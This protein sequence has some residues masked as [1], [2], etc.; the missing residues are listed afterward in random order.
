VI[1]VTGGAGFIGSHLCDALVA[2]GE[3]VRVLDDLSTGSEANLA[4]SRGS[5]E[6][7]R[8]SIVDPAAVARAVARAEVVFHLAAIPSV[9]RSFEEPELCHAVNATGTLNV[10]LAAARAKVRRLVFASSCAIYGDAGRQAIAEKR[11]PSPKSP[12]AAQKLLGEHYLTLYGEAFGLA[13]VALR[14]FNVYGPRQDPRSPYSGVISIFCERALRG[15]QVTIHGDGR[16]TRDFVEVGDVVQ[17]LLLAADAQGACGIFN[18]GSGSSHTLL[19]LHREIAR[20]TGSTAA[21]RHGPARPGDVRHS[22]A[23]IGKAR[24]TLG[25]EP[26]VALDAGLSRTLSWYRSGSRFATFRSRDTPSTPG[27]R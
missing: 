8:C 2:R 9:P 7:V 26:R 5:I 3:T 20:L 12:Y 10:A 14:F 24:A 18:V 13:T 16:Q 19:D 1:L 17:A 22:A 23:A 15:E 27:I 11:A 25:Y 4:Q 21:S 6:L